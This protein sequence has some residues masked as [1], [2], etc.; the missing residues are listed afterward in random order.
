MKHQDA[1]DLLARETARARSRIARERALRAGFALA[2]VVGVWALLALAGA[3]ET[4]PMLAQSL[5]SL[6]ALGVFAW[7]GWRAY[8]A[9]RAPTE[10][11]AR[12]R[13]AA[14]SKMDAGAFDALRD[15]P[16]K[17]D[18]FS[19]ALWARE[20]ERAV[21]RAQRVRVGPARARLDDY[22][23][24]KLRFVLAIALLL[25]VLYAGAQAPDRLAR[26]FFPD[27]GPLLGDQ[28]LAVEAWLTPAEYTHAAP[29][30]LSDVIG[31]RVETP[32]SVTAMVR[33]TGPAGAPL[34]VFEGLSGRREVRFAR[35]ADGAWQAE[36]ELPGA[37]QLKI[38]RF[39]TRA[40]WRIAPARD[41]RPS[42]AFSAPID[43]L[44]E[45]HLALSYRVSDD[46]GVR[47]LALRVRP[48][49]PPEGLLQADPVD[50][51]LEFPAGDPREAEE[52]VEVDVAAHPYAGMEVEAYVV[53][54][55][56]LGQEG[57]SDPLRLTLPERVF[58]QP[59]AQ[60]AIEIRRHILAERRAYQRAR[61]MREETMEDPSLLVEGERIEVRNYD[62]R[63]NLARAPEGIR[64]G[65]R[66]IDAL[67]MMPEDGYFRDLAVYLGFRTARAELDVA[68]ELGDTDLAADTL[69]RTA[70]R[71]EYGGA[72]DARR[73]L[74]EAQRQLAEALAAGAPQERINQLLEALRRATENYMEALVNEALRNGERA[75]M[76]DTEE[77]AQISGQDIEE[78]LR[79]VERLSREGRNAE[80]QQL[81]ELLAGILANMQVNL[82]EGGEG[83]SG[84]GDQALQQSMD[85]LSEAM[86]EQR[87]L[88]DETQQSQSGQGGQSGGQ[89]GDRQAA[90]R[91][92][93]AEAQRMADDAG[94][95]PSEDLDAA[96]EAMRRAEDALRRGDLDAAEAAQD[97]AL[98]NLREGA[99]ALSAEMR[100]RER[101]G[102]QGNEAGEAGRDPLG[103]SIN[104]GSDSEGTVPT[105]TDPVRAREIYDEIRRRAQDPNRPEAEREYLRRL[106]DRFGDS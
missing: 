20:R 49:N 102:E 85:E 36:L 79:E 17:Y 73:A 61:P 30:S 69:W 103:R 74:D 42:A 37:G 63:P 18:P 39:H 106:M 86:G 43:V 26:A 2:V 46:F 91:Q 55:D 64:H 75:N 98:E 13:L 51:P 57:V 22:D 45:E 21:E 29:V 19:M 77:Q 54:F 5:A 83:G 100:D 67:T 66:L 105:T 87:A 72:A 47:R 27:P 96:G 28:E 25:G 62:R 88:R 52:D 53:A 10:A 34:L 80:A 92:G 23:P 59:L 41:V 7:L 78:L 1:L 3:L 35:A 60:A 70:L 14:D 84:E 15:Q 68:N 81:L 82:A 31:Q 99:E 12:A 38:V 101:E 48:L 65:A 56:A 104:G 71:A 89:L 24:F 11:E 90:I 4:L 50:T 8:L 9:W 44:P 16:T 94:A 97:A 40:F 33:V 58:L 32:P 93:L 6:G 76:E 95:A